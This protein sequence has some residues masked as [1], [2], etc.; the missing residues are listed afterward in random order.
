MAVA[1]EI[2]EDFRATLLY[3]APEVLIS[4]YGPGD[5][6]AYSP[7]ADIWSLGCTYVEMLTSS[8]PYFEYYDDCE[9]FY[10]DVLSRAHGPLESQLPYDCMSLVPTASTITRFLVNKIFD[11]CEATRIS[12]E[13]LINFLQTLSADNLHHQTKL[14]GEFQKAYES[15]QKTFGSQSIVQ[16]ASKKRGIFQS[17]RGLSIQS[18]SK[19]RGTDTKKSNPSLSNVSEG[20]L[21]E[22]PRSRPPSRAKRKRNRNAR[23]DCW[24]CFSYCMSRIIYFTG[25]FPLVHGK[26]VPNVPAFL[27]IYLKSFASVASFVFLGLT[28][29]SMFFLIA[30][31]VVFAVR[32]L[33]AQFCECDLMAPPIL[34]ISG[35]FVILLFGLLFR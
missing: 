8:P 26:T 13:G 35:I 23:R 32:K 28:A 24:F 11:K 16:T 3:V 31:G 21:E 12:A 2:T 29:L 4:E 9:N 19:I 27:G 7:S 20:T 6:R 15:S 34:I 25:S 22:G 17:I 18:L 10:T 1:S 30:F 14:E 5:R 33:V